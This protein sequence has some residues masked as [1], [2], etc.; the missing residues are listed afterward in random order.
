MKWKS[1]PGTA[2]TL[3]AVL[4]SF[5]LFAL[6]PRSNGQGLEFKN[7]SVESG[8]PGADNTVYRFPLVTNGVDALVKINGRSNAQVRLVSIDLTNAGFDKA[9]Q[10]QVTYGQNNQAPS[11]NSDWWMEF[12]VTFVMTGTNTTVTVP[13]F[14][15]TA[16]D[17]DGNGD[18][19]R[20]YVGMYGLSTYS[21]EANTQLGYGSIVE[22]VSNVPTAVGTLFLGPVTNYNNI[23]T[24]ATRVMATTN[25][26]TKNS[27]RIRTGARST[28]V[29]GAADR[30]YCLWFKS[31]VYQ[32]PS[33]LGLPVSLKGFNAKL[34][35]KKP[36][37]NWVSSLE[38]NLS[39]YIVERSTNG[40]DYKD[41]VYVFATGTA[42]GEA[43][44]NY[45]D[46][47]VPVSKGILYYRL[48]MVDADGKFKY[49][50]TRIIRLGDAN[51][52]LAIQ[53][54]PNPAVNE[55]RITIPESWQDKAVQYT[56]LNSNGQ[57]M[58]RFTRANASQTET[59]DLSS[60]PVGAYLIQAGTSE[61][62]AIQRFV[63]SK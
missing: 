25:Y 39:H 41:V 61:E 51:L 37:L 44:Y 32:T 55:I 29:S 53:V 12:Q 34:E 24:G 13:S 14:S 38:D 18:K 5:A 36:V 40:Q 23:D 31:F 58:R 57:V 63:K 1:Y 6:I 60:M 17:I 15:L 48:K 62:S 54:Y 21:L 49:S 33:E 30:M 27:F 8:N 59:I 3:K 56:L 43:K 10:P 26:L 20:E 52:N 50:E 45:T 28:G 42:K 16:L 7:V 22:N 35:A 2:K 46:P 19:I 4:L 9:F 11:G 47:A